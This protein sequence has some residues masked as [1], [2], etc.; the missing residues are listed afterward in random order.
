MN[1]P[2]SWSEE[3]ESVFASLLDAFAPDDAVVLIQSYFDESYN[4]SLLCVGGYTFR[5]R[6]GRLL[7]RDWRKMLRRYALPYFRMSACNA[8]QPPFDGL[9]EAQCVAVA[10]EAIRLI[11]E[12]AEFG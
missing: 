11:N 12:Y 7:D 5:R 4:P 6:D 2:E 9:T 1:A 8:R 10:T 3:D